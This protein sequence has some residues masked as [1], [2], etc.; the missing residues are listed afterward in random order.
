MVENKNLL[1]EM[2]AEICRALSHPVRLQILDLIAEKEM[3]SSDLLEILEIPKANLSQHLTVL[4]DAG[5]LKMRREGQFQYLFLGLPRIKEAC[6]IVR[7]CL[8]DRLQEQS[9]M[10]HKLQKNLKKVTKK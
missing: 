1:Y 8:S 9:E 5:I 7:G 2:Q 3:T 4:K 6:G 10:V